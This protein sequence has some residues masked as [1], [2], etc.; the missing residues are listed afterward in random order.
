MHIEDLRSY[1]LSKKGSTESLPFGPETLVFKVMNK[2]F[3]L[4]PMEPPFSI[5]LKCNPELAI[6][7]R[8]KF[9][10][11]TPGYHMNK[12]HWNTIMIDGSIPDKDIYVYI[13]NSYSLIVSSLN[14]KE[15]ERLS[16]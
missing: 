3:A 13:D 8:D 4:M 15:Q 5:N 10:A 14:K 2:M 11:I 16:K 7:L 9:D 1:C 12:A 6:E